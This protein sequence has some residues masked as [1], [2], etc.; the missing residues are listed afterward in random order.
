M[1]LRRRSVRLKLL[2]PTCMLFGIGA[3]AMGA[4]RVSPVCRGITAMLRAGLV[5]PGEI[6]G[7][8]YRKGADPR[9]DHLVE[10]AGRTPG[11]DEVPGSP[12]VLRQVASPGALPGQG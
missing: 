1:M 8:S 2:L 4:D 6:D 5:K 3:P 12:G 7:A 9:L 10:L 11:M